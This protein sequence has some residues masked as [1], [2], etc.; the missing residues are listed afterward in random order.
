MAGATGLVLLGSETPE[1]VRAL[2]STADNCGAETIWIACHLFQRDPVTL[3]SAVLSA[4]ERV[5]V[6]LMSLSPYSIHPVYAAMAAAT[7]DEFYPGR[8]RLCFG[9][10]APRD[11][12]AAGIEAPRPLTTLGEAVEIARRLLGG[13]TIAFRGERFRVEGR[14]LAT[15]ARPLP[16]LLAASGSRMLELAGKLADGVL[17]SG[18]ASPEFVAWSLERV[19]R[20][21]VAAGGRTIRKIGIVWASIDEE[22]RRAHDRLRRNLAFVLRGGHHARNLALAGT[23]LDQAALAAAYAREDWTAVDALV[24]D[25]VVSRHAASGS[26]DQASGALVCYRDAGLD[27]V[28]VAG[29]SDTET[30]R[31]L[32]PGN[33]EHRAD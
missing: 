17:I 31:R 25:A 33:A 11:R 5:A 27:E 26:L 23:Q 3:A 16:V 8:V 21:E 2:A 10:G 13:A 30:L 19:R 7:L 14:K 12:A 1:M 18:G 29:I 15:G 20:G 9:V 28:A 24:T 4:T 22:P 32:I 6:G